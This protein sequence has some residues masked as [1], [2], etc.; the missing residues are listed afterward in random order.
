M[1]C[2]SGR[3]NSAAHLTLQV[4]GHLQSI[5]ASAYKIWL[6]SRFSYHVIGAEKHEKTNEVEDEEHPLTDIV[7]VWK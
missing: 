5:N 1:V 7:C 4:F 6:S 2:Y 3:E